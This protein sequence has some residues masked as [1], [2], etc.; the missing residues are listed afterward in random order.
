MLR[1]LNIEFHH[2]IGNMTSG[3]MEIFHY[4]KCYANIIPMSNL[5]MTF[6]GIFFVIRL[7]IVIDQAQ[8]AYVKTFQ[9]KFLEE[10]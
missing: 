1:R 7:K 6:P 9:K 4:L 10:M 5:L 2:W 8:P 3:E